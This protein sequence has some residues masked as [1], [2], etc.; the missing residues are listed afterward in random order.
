MRNKLNDN[1]CLLLNTD[2][3]LKSKN[4]TLAEIKKINNKEVGSEVDFQRCKELPE[5]KRMR[6]N[7]ATILLN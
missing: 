3:Q 4:K 2:Y 5:P 7:M 1:K 6:K